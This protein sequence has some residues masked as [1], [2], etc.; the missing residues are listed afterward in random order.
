[1]STDR[2]IQAL[3]AG[4]SSALKERERLQRKRLEHVCPLCVRDM[5]SREYTAVRVYRCQSCRFCRQTA[6]SELW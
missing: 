2:D 3:R 6:R 1:V 5:A 4:L